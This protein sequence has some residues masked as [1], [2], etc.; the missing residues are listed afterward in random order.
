MNLCVHLYSD[1]LLTVATPGV[2]VQTNTQKS[3]Q[4]SKPQQQW[5]PWEQPKWGNH[6][7]P[8]GAPVSAST[9]MSSSA[10]PHAGFFYTPPR[11]PR[12]ARLLR[13][14][15]Q[16][17]PPPSRTPRHSNLLSSAVSSPQGRGQR[18]AWSCGRLSV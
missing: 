7:N 10:S 3:A 11:S 5:M 12:S 4:F 16:G 15:T 8:P 6:L 13:C 1:V 9:A 17:G 14:Q 2:Q 18:A